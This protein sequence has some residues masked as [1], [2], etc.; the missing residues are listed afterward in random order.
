MKLLIF[1]AALFA[2]SL[3]AC[4]SGNSAAQKN[5]VAPDETRFA[6]SQPAP[7]KPCINLNTATAEEL[8][9]LPKVGEVLA[10]RIIEHRER[11][12]PFRRPQDIIII[13]GFSER[14][15]RAL[16]PLVCVE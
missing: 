3:T 8:T 6:L 16:A 5:T 9:G 15:Y 12:G 7:R 14:K 13:D 11:N 1:S 10:R 2:L 4:K